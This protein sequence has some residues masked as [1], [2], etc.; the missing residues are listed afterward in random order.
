MDG[1]S[2]VPTSVSEDGAKV[3][4]FSNMAL[5]KDT[6]LTKIESELTKIE[7][8][9]TKTSI[10]ISIKPPAGRGAA[11]NLAASHLLLCSPASAAGDDEAWA[12][13]RLGC[14]KAR[15]HF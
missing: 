9:L 6:E 11:T 7:T 2:H 14:H 3:Q 12:H 10:E 13:P 4:T 5:K 8:E 1:V 15:V